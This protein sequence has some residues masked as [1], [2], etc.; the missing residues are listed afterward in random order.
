MLIESLR[1]HGVCVMYEVLS[2]PWGLGLFVSVIGLLGSVAIFGVL[3]AVS[4]WCRLKKRG[5]TP[6]RMLLDMEHS[7]A[8]F[9]YRRALIMSW[10]FVSMSVLFIVSLAMSI[11]SGAL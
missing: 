3:E 7:R 11:A 2:D 1:G 5:A 6:I 4:V 9:K 8:V 10:V